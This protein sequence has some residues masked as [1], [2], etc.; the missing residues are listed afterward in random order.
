MVDFASGHQEAPKP[1]LVNFYSLS[2]SAQFHQNDGALLIES[3]T[4]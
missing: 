3:I 1:A 2:A 4:S